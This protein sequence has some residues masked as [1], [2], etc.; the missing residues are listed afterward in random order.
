M[1]F[2]FASNLQEHQL[3]FQGL[4]A[5]EPAVNEASQLIAKAFASGNKLMLCG[6]GGSA[7]D[8]QHIAA[9][10]TGRFIKDR[11]PLP[12]IALT[13]DT[14]A[15]TCIAN[16]YSF[17]DVFA[18]QIG[19]LGRSGDVLIAI[20]TSGNS[21]NVIQAMHVAKELGIQIEWSGEGLT[22][23]G[24]D[25]ATGLVRVEVDPRYFRPTE[26][27]TLLGD[28]TKAKQQLGWVPEIT[29]DQMIEEMVAYDLEQAKQHALLKDHGYKVHVG[30][31]N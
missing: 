17:E 1:T 24:R 14:S 19:A 21:G 30:K 2:T 6:N 18:R 4:D 28:P 5:L 8:S 11:K 26:V 25:A 20:S 12:A 31:E 23:I 15:L 3:L 16:D 29:L 9:E 10:M 7:A 22:E 27:E 13:T